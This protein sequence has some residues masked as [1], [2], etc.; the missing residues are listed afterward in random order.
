VPAGTTLTTYTGSCTITTAGTVIDAKSVNCPSGLDID[1]ANV[2]ISRSKVNG[3]ITVDTDVNRSWSLTL[4]DSEVIGENGDYPAITNGNV[5]ILRANIHGGHN[6]LECQ[7][8]SAHCQLQDSWIHGQWQ[9]TTGATHLGGFLDLG[10]QVTCNGNNGNCVELIHNSIVCDPPANADGGGCTGDI[11]LLPHWGPLNGAVIQNNYLGANPGASFCTYGGDGMEY[12][13]SNIVYTGN[14]FQRGPN[15][16]CA[17]Y[18]PV[19]NFDTT[20]AG[21]VWSNNNYDDGT[22]VQPQ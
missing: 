3:S 9:S 13:A 5:T 16:Q 1:A 4:T 18:G 2:T 14:V 7:E 12:P 6:G 17:A 15:R 21:N 8:H 22:P 19:T 10:E 20:A 11:N